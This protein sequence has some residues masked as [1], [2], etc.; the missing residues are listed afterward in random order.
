ME[1][2]YND[3]LGTLGYSYKAKVWG[4]DLLHIFK[5]SIQSTAQ[6]EAEDIITPLQDLKDYCPLI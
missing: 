4:L 5:T 1:I 6:W 3:I 2:Y